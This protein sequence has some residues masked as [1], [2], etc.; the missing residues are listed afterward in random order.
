MITIENMGKRLRMV[1]EFFKFTQ[2][3]I[4]PMTIFVI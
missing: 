2:Q 3:K 1:R 4:A